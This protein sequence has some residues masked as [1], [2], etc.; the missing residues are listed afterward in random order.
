VPRYST[1][2]MKSGRWLVLDERQQGII[3][4]DT[5]EDALLWIASA[6]DDED[7]LPGLQHIDG[8]PGGGACNCDQE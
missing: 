8:C 4:T 5:E 2:E 1:M 7:N 3:S 6:I